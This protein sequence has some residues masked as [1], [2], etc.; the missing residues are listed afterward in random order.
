MEQEKA[1]VLNPGV[2]PWQANSKCV[3]L[4]GKKY[5]SP[6]HD[7]TWGGRTDV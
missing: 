7:D 4:H 6:H 1:D 5:A 3:R 2:E